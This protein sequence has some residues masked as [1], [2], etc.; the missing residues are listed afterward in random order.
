MQA[1]LRPIYTWLWN[2]LPW[3]L[4]PHKITKVWHQLYI[5]YVLLAKSAVCKCKWVARG[6]T[7]H[8][9]VVHLSSPYLIWRSEKWQRGG[10]LVLVSWLAVGLGWWPQRRRATFV[11]LMARWKWRR[12]RESPDWIGYE[13]GRVV[14]TFGMLMSL[15]RGHFSYW[16]HALL[17]SPVVICECDVSYLEWVPHKW[18]LFQRVV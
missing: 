6:Q 17:I 3:Q 18:F 16:L 13:T 15:L 9:V 7:P 4:T 8:S 12:E 10:R 14:P 5:P 11:I 1:N 2:E